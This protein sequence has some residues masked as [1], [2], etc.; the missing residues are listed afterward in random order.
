MW[1]SCGHSPKFFARLAQS[2]VLVDIA[3]KVLFEP[4]GED[5]PPRVMLGE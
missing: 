3:A 1:K 4:E 2:M 5:V